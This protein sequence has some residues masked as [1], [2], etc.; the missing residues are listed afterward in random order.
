[1]QYLILMTSKGGS[2]KST[3]ACNFYLEL[4][5]RG[6]RVTG[7]DSDPQQHFKSFLNQQEQ[8]AEN[9]ITIID[10]QGAWT[11]DNDDLLKKVQELDYK[12]IVPVCPSDDDLKAALIMSNRLT[13]ANV[14][15][16][17]VFVMNSVYRENDLDTKKYSSQLIQHG[18]TVSKYA[19]QNL[20]GFKRRDD[21]GKHIDQIQRFFHEQGI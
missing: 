6:S 15:N 13:N 11:T 1:M 9:D 4:V 3:L 5:R 18:L 20:K 21:K 19:F 17:T 12:I 7:M 16:N 14:I 2:G 8:H 10:T